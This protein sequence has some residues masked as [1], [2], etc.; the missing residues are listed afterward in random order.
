MVVFTVVEAEFTG[1]GTEGGLTTAAM[2]GAG[3]GGEYREK[4]EERREHLWAQG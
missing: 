2:L 1:A 4:K 3:G